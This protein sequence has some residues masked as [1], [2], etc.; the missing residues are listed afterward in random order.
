MRTGH[1]R[2]G[3]R[4]HGFLLAILG[5]L[6][7]LGVALPVVAQDPDVRA[8]ILLRA[9]A[10]ERGLAGER[11]ELRI[12]VIGGRSGTSA[13][14]A[15]GMTS[16]L[17]QLSSQVRVAGRTLSVSAAPY[18]DARSTL[19]AI[20]ARRA[21]VVYVARD[22]G[23]AVSDLAGPLGA[24]GRIM[25]CGDPSAVGQ[26]CLLSVER[27]GSR[28]RVVIHLRLADAIGKRF[29][30]RLLRLSRVVR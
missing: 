27:N 13:A 16:A 24:D 1:A 6:A 25:M 7:C 12:L 9:M 28:M 30:A 10:Y 3:V 5:L 4:R 29:D 2:R 23:D 20:R 14:D 8:A 26:G 15:R 19:A 21:D 22:L 17:R 18:E 11:G